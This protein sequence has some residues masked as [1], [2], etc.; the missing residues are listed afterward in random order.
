MSIPLRFNTRLRGQRRIQRLSCVI[1]ARPCCP[2]QG[3]GSD[4]ALKLILHE[5]SEPIHRR[6]APMYRRDR[7]VDTCFRL[8]RMS[9]SQIAN[10]SARSAWSCALLHVAG[11]LKAA[12]FCTCCST[13]PRSRLLRESFAPLVG[14]ACRSNVVA[15]AVV[16]CN[17]CSE[18]HRCT[19]VSSR[20]PRASAFCAACRQTRSA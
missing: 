6:A 10:R 2:E 15:H 12:A 19:T 20:D 18:H 13:Q 17:L 14:P 8:F 9:L 1:D 11:G 5:K 7:I 16:S 3:S 4:E